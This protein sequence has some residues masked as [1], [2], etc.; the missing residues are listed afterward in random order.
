M[1]TVHSSLYIRLKFAKGQ[2]G[3]S[4]EPNKLCRV[5]ETEMSQM[6]F[7]ELTLLFF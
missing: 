7:E 1:L 3:T 2:K 5:T 4:E 6:I